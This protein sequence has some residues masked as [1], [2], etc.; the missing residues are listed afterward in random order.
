MRIVACTLV[1]CLM[2][3]RESNGELPKNFGAKQKARIFE[4]K[5]EK[6]FH[7]HSTMGRKYKGEGN[8]CYLI[9]SRGISQLYYIVVR[10]YLTGE[11]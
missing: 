2:R 1:L 4:K 11:Q 6:P 10:L 5:E 9:Y 8:I 3:E 7:L